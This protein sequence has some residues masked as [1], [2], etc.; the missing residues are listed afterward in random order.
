MIT[1][2]AKVTYLLGAGASSNC[3]PTYSNF[4]ERFLVFRDYIQ[5]HRNSLASADRSSS[6]NLISLCNSVLEQLIFHSTP[7]TI[8]KKYFHSK[9]NSD[10]NLNKLKSILTLYFIFEQSLGQTAIEGAKIQKKSSVEKRYDSFI[11]SIL[12]PIYSEIK[13]MQNFSILTWNYDLQFEICFK[14]YFSGDF[15]EAQKVVQSIPAPETIKNDFSFNKDSFS[16]IHLNG[17]AYSQKSEEFTDYKIPFGIFIDND[18][19]IIKNLIEHFN[20]VIFDSNKGNKYLNFAWERDKSF[21]QPKDVLELT[22]KCAADVAFDTE[23]LVIIGYSFPIFNREIDL[24]LFEKM[25]KLDQ[26]FIQSPI[27]DKLKKIIVEVF[28]PINNRVHASRIVVIDDIDYFHIPHRA[29]E[30]I[31]GRIGVF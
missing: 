24:Q 18:Q 14:N 3:L 28:S 5:R 31:P 13:L 23:I 25:K 2:M 4:R 10:D 27:A 21:P 19:L 8:A 7:D 15:R 9:T 17:V 26:I 1:E 11:A 29:E 22:F 16:I 12:Q 6:D 30:P 20:S